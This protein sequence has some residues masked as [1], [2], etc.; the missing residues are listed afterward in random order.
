MKSS[1]KFF[2][3]FTVLFVVCTTTSFAQIF[4]KNKGK[5]VQKLI[6]KTTHVYTYGKAAY[7]ERLKISFNNYWNV[8]AFEFHDI[9]GGLPSMDDE[10]AVFMPA[11]VSLTVRDNETA[12]N[13][14][15]FVYG[16]AGK[17]GM[18]SGEA[19]V[20]AFPVNAFHYEF[21]VLNEN[22]MYS[23]SLLRL[24]Y[25][26]YCLNDMLTY[27]KN[28]GSDNGYFKTIDKKTE[29]IAGKTMIIPA[30]LT[31]EW[32]VNPNTTALM[33]NRMEAG[34]KPMKAI[35]AKVLDESDIS[36]NGKYKIM[37]TEDIIKLEQTTEADKYT[38]FLPA[39]SNSKY[40]MVFDL[41]TKELLYYDKVVMGMRVKDKDFDKLNKAAGL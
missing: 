8:S 30:D 32:D 22:N 20:A 38:L 17:S 7:T 11:V 5:N 6:A 39:I 16:E 35:M 10:S 31:S 40:V 19:I 25:M 27:I 2:M 34:R 29:R 3:G 23:R 12:M 18:V 21:D 41:K 13:S 26:V 4:D 14:P 9:S 28:N 36:F 1:G 15:F 24:P 33:K 37:K